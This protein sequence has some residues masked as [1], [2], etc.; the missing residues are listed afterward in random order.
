MRLDARDLV[1][2]LSLCTN[3]DPHCG[4]ER[5]PQQHRNG[6]PVTSEGEQPVHSKQQPPQPSSR[7]HVRPG[8]G[9]TEG[10]SRTSPLSSASEGHVSR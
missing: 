10:F 8:L 2:V 7:Q 1:L 5:K 4:G 3:N 9:D 6:T